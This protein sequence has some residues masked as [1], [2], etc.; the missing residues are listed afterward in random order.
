MRA[1]GVD[2]IQEV[3]PR[4]TAKDDDTE[5]NEGR[6][7]PALLGRV[8]EMIMVKPGPPAGV[9]EK[10]TDLGTNWEKGEAE[11]SQTLSLDAQCHGEGYGK[12]E[13]Q[14]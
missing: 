6:R 5:G 4:A 13:R 1:E 12:L 9:K 2:E 11:K 3:F 8:A 10:H 7:F 14:T